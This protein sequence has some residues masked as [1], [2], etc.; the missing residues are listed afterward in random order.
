MSD[1][2]Q[3]ESPYA[4]SPTPDEPFGVEELTSDEKN[5]AAL[6]HLVTLA[7]SFTLLLGTVA[8]LVLWMVKKDESSFVDHHG[9]QALN[10]Q[11]TLI[12]AFG[13][14]FVLAC[15]YIGFLF[16]FVLYFA[17]IG[18]TIYA[19]IKASEGERYEY[20]MTIQFL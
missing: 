11:I 9:K 4:Y 15:L 2:Q 17:N 13:I 3:S 1:E 16:M 5:M 18:L 7:N 19:G 14:S 8:C 12:L 6:C 10:F 20:P